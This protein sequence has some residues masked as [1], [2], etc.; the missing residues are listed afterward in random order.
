[1]GEVLLDVSLI[2]C[3]TVCAVAAT[4]CGGAAG[5]PADA[6]A[7]DRADP[8]SAH[9]ASVRDG[10]HRHDAAPDRDDGR[11]HDAAKSE[12]AADGSSFVTAPHEL[13]SIP[14]MGGPVLSHAT[15]VTVTFA[16][17]S[18]R[19]FV[20]GLGAYLVT[21]PWLSV[22]G[23]EYGVGLG[24]SV[25]VEL[26]TVAPA[27]ITDSEIQGLVESLVGA[28]T[29]P[30]PEAGVVA[31]EILPITDGGPFDAALDAWDG[32]GEAGPPVDMPEAVYMLYFPPTTTVTLLGQPICDVS[33]GGYHYQTSLSSSGRA[34]AYAVITGCPGA[35]KAELVQ[36]ISHE[37]I[38]AATDP[39]AGDLAYAITDPSSPWS[40]IGGEVGDL[41][42]FLAPQWTEGGYDGIQRVYSN[43]SAADGRD[44]CLPSSS[45]YYGTSLSPSA[46]QKVAPGGTATVAVSGWSTAPVPDWGLSAALY[47]ASPPSFAPTFELSAA[48]L[49]NG[50]SAILTISV[51]AGS[52]SGSTA[53]GLVYSEDSVAR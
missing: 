44:P 26:T 3:A 20:E 52:S 28:G 23:P 2:A 21:S 42:S 7:P 33:G 35:S 13:P 11:A 25:N 17:D 37:L 1:M 32:G 40:F 38:E 41:C 34:F 51:P 5:Q 50:G 45:P 47:I 6:A 15:L 29:A 16:D 10:G 39:S 46:A 14:D 49:N 12:A 31:R 4:A 43:A 53:L 9:D 22:V 36:A 24:S 8:S 27:T 48:T 18:E 30:E 19:S